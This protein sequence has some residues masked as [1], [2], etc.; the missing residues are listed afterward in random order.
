MTLLLLRGFVDLYPS[1]S[2]LGHAAFDRVEGEEDAFFFFGPFGRQRQGLR[3]GEHLEQLFFNGNCAETFAHDLPRRDFQD[4]SSH[5]VGD[6]DDRDWWRADH[7]GGG[8]CLALPGREGAGR[9]FD[10]HGLFPA[11]GDQ[12]IHR[13]RCM[14][15][16]KLHREHH[17]FLN[18]RRL[19][20]LLFEEKVFDDLSRLSGHFLALFY[21]LIENREDLLF[22][23]SLF[24]THSGFFISSS[25][26]SWQRSLRLLDVPGPFS[27]P[28]S[29]LS[30]QLFFRRLSR[31]LR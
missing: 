22:A 21:L 13:R 19:V 8:N 6:N 25:P 18:I 3:F 30:R 28:F 9:A 31:G 27:L 29:S 7:P 12:K 4:L 15:P 1:V 2:A 11:N 14:F 23:V 24:F 17:T 16:V 26:A 10:D 20:P 5:G